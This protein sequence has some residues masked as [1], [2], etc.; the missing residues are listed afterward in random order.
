MKQYHVKGWAEF[1]HYKDRSPAW[2]KLHKS[3]L[4][5]YEFHC[6]PLASRAL[7]PM[8]WLLA[9]ENEDPMS[10]LIPGDMKKIAFRLRLTVKEVEEAIKPLIDNGFI[11]VL[12]DASTTLAEPEQHAIPE[13]ERETEK[14]TYR[15][16]RE[17][18]ARSS[19]KIQAEPDLFEQ[20][21]QA[22]PRQRRGDRDKALT[23]YRKALAKTTEDKIHAAVIRYASSRD[24]AQGFAAGAAAWL[25]NAGYDNNPIPASAKPSDGLTDY[26]RGLLGAVAGFGANA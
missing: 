24:V 23:A 26:E 2:V 18:E 4:D 3:L 12:Q 20:F 6:L 8:L 14:E 21:W 9:S 19:K 15:E 5:N 1:Q 17:I 22:F 25:N 13:K 10:G 7:A 11:E 16:E